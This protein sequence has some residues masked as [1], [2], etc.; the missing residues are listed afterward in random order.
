[1]QD[2]RSRPIPSDRMRPIEAGVLALLLAE[3]WPW[4][5]GE[6]AQRLRLPADLIAVCEATL[7]ADG[8]VVT[9]SGKLRASWAAVRGDELANWH[10]SIKRLAR[11]QLLGAA[12]PL[13]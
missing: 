12:I 4:L 5:P 11:M 7:R 6:L 2:Q 9:R 13:H 8:L 1:M 3:D 10:D